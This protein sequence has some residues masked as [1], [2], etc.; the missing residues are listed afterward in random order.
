MGTKSYRPWNPDQSFPLSPSPRD[1]LPE[2]HLVDFLLDLLPELDLSKIE[3]EIQKKDPRETRPYSPRMMVGLLIYGYCV[4]VR[5]SRKLE[6]LT[7]HDVAFR[8]LTGGQHPD[9]SRISQFRKDH[10]EAFQDLFLQV[11]RLCSDGSP[12][13]K[14]QYNFTDSESRIMASGGSFTQGYNCQA[15]VDEEAQIIVAADLSNQ[16]PDNGYLLPVLAQVEENCGRMPKVTSADSGYWAPK[17]AE[18]CEAMGTDAYCHSPPAARRAPR[19]SARPAGR[20]G[21]Q[22]T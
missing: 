5:S 12:D 15:A 13:A 1:W 3:G 16:P 8:V 2:G 9:H 6:R 14:A 22:P 21:A 7:Y 18:G 4:G 11:L 10:Q 20:G 17:N 19:A